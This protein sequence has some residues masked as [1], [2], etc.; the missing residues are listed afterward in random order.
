[1]TLPAEL[2]T[3]L[4]DKSQSQRRESEGEASA[5]RARAFERIIA[6][7]RTWRPT[8]TDAVDALP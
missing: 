3:E 2:G 7:T 1:M 4:Q 5:E 6:E 8:Q